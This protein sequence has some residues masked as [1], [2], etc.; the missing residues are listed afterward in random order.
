MGRSQ[1]PHRIRRRSSA[2]D[3]V[4]S[5]FTGSMNVSCECSVSS[6]R[7]LC[8]ELITHPQESYRPWCVVGSRNLVNEEALAHWG[9]GGC[10]N[11]IN[12][13]IKITGVNKTHILMTPCALICVF[14]Q[15]NF[16]QCDF[17]L[18]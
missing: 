18:V 15:T 7:G 8:Y 2:V 14:L 3:I 1:W 11:K 16:T 5:N 13:T 6:G 10:C 17:S 4:G 12:K 9:G